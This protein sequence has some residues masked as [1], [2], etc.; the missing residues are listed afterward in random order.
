[1]DNDFYITYINEAAE[2]QYGRKASEVLG[3]RVQELYDY[4]WVNPGDEQASMEAIRDKG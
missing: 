4:T 2:K 1:V 3:L